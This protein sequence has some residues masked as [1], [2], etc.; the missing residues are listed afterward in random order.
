MIKAIPK[1]SLHTKMIIASILIFF[2][3]HLARHPKL[4]VESKIV[5]CHFNINLVLQIAQKEALLSQRKNVVFGTKIN[6]MLSMKDCN[7]MFVMCFVWEFQAR[8]LPWSLRCVL[9]R[10]F[11]GGRR[12]E[13]NSQR[14]SREQFVPTNE[15]KKD[16]IIKGYTYYI[17]KSN[18]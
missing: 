2:S 3:N 7:K 13:T 9:R 14:E 15:S 8:F 4:C 6:V 11:V 10:A 1:Y 5:F 18:T 17:D 12:N 16:K